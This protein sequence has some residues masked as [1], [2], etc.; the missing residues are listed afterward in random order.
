M[1]K[2]IGITNTIGQNFNHFGQLQ[3]RMGPKSAIDPF[4]HIKVPPTQQENKGISVH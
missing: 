1:G 4:R 2:P 3:G